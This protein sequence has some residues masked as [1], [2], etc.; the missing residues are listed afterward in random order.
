[1]ATRLNATAPIT[2]PGTPTSFRARVRMYRHGLGDCFLLTLPRELG[3][4]C[5]ILIDCGALSRK[6]GEM[7]ALAGHIRDSVRAGKEGK[8][9]VDV[10]I[11]THEHKDHVSGF[12]QARK[13]F[14][15]D[16]DFRSVWLAW[17]ENLSER[18]SQRL[19]EAKKSA[20]AKLQGLAALAGSSRLSLDSDILKGVNGVLAFSRD[21]DHTP[22]GRVSNAMEYLKERGLAAEDFATSNRASGVRHQP[23]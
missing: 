2:A 12:N 17:T 4:P 20:I 10:V 22:T 11:G 15:D 9:V 21:E 7:E 16:F 19:K 13:V 23:L 3:D 8:A 5:Q 14:N 6:T 1:M 18:E